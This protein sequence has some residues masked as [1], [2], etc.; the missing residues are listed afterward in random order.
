MT[1][2]GMD[3]AMLDVVA[4]TTGTPVILARSLLA[5]IVSELIASRRPA[6]V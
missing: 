4:E 2:I 3:D 6:L 1:C 5:R